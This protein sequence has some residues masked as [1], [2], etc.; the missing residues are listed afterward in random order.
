MT[1]A[2]GLTKSH[3]KPTSQPA[4][5]PWPGGSS[6]D[7]PNI[8]ETRGSC[9]QC[10][11]MLDLSF[12]YHEGAG[13]CQ[14]RHTTLFLNHEHLMNILRYQLFGADQSTQNS[15]RPSEI[16]QDGRHEYWILRCLEDSRGHCQSQCPKVRESG[17]LQELGRPPG[18]S[19]VCKS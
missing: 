19:C 16:Y 17:K 5:N 8:L 6:W 1:E 3:Q 13:M 15:L 18:W 12:E 10:W 4:K 11:I 2:I 14:P 9:L 7:G